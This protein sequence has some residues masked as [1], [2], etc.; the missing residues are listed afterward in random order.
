MFDMF[1]GQNKVVS[2]RED[3]VDDKEKFVL[4][5]ISNFITEKDKTIEVAFIIH[6][7]RLGYKWFRSCVF[8]PELSKEL[9][10]DNDQF[11]MV[12]GDKVFSLSLKETKEKLNE[13]MVDTYVELTKKIFLFFQE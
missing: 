4:E 9:V 5:W 7:D 13:S 3:L 1:L 8:V 12:K 2:I 11:C 6:F 10:K